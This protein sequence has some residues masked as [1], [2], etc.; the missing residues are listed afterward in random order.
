MSWSDESSQWLIDLF[1]YDCNIELKITQKY[2]DAFD[3]IQYQIILKLN[4]NLFGRLKELVNKFK[5]SKHHGISNNIYHC[6]YYSILY[7]LLENHELDVS[8]IKKTY[9]RKSFV[10]MSSWQLILQT[11]QYNKMGLKMTPHANSKLYLSSTSI[12][13]YIDVFTPSAEIGNLCQTIRDQHPRYNITYCFGK[14]T[15]T[16]IGNISIKNVRINT[17]ILSN[18]ETNLDTEISSNEE[19]NLDSEIP[20][21]EETDTEIPST[22]E[23]VAISD[24]EIDELFDDVFD[25]ESD[26]INNETYRPMFGTT[27]ALSNG[28][29]R[30]KPTMLEQFHKTNDVNDIDD[31]LQ[32]MNKI[33]KNCTESDEIDIK[34]MSMEDD[35]IEFRNTSLTQLHSAIAQK[36]L[37]NKFGAFNTSD[38][39]LAMVY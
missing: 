39:N 35:I 27:T 34:T 5:P 24:K 4:N 32:F 29:L 33:K 12:R 36:E 37:T 17:E 31:A 3:G 6:I 14:N 8:K 19:T 7:V 10:L 16:Y 28:T 26:D 9:R 1:K 25:N 30:G 23:I 11:P 21:N 2:H 22:E 13:N 38:L 15:Q 20:S 18:E